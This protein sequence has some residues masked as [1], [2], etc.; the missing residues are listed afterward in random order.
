MFHIQLLHGAPQCD[1]GKLI[2]LCLLNKCC[3]GV[4]N[5]LYYFSMLENV[6]RNWFYYQ[7]SSV[8]VH[9]AATCANSNTKGS[10]WRAGLC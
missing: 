10:I 4:Q 6:A 1:E 2:F 7:Y 3:H 9:T 8:H 5:L